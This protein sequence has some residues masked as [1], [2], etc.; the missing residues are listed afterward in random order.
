MPLTQAE[1][2]TLRDFMGFGRPDAPN[3]FIGMEE[4]GNDEAL[5]HLRAQWVGQHIRDLFEAHADLGLNQHHLLENALSQTTWRGMCALMVLMAHPNLYAAWGAPME[6][7]SQA[8][9]DYQVHRLGRTDPTLG[10]TFLTELLPIPRPDAA[11]PIESIAPQ[12]AN[13]AAYELAMIPYRLQRIEELLAM[14]QALELVVC[15]G[16]GRWGS[17]QTIFP[18]VQFEAPP[19]AELETLRLHF[20]PNETTRPLDLKFGV[21][22]GQTLVVFIHHFTGNNVTS[23]GRLA[24]LAQLIRVRKEALLAG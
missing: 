6:A 17:L 4:R 10:E 20:Y 24:A 23:W 1:V 7:V 14:P 16:K 2:S 11:T 19:A 12:F 18:D 21:Y 8:T 3:W 15:Y 22:Q 13:D 9:L 5:L